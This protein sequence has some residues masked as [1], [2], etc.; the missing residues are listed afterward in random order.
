MEH[1]NPSPKIIA[2]L[3]YLTILG[4]IASLIFNNNHPSSLAKFHIR[5]ALG[6]HL[7]FVAAGLVISVPIVGWIT[8]GLAWLFAFVLWL[9][10]VLDA[11]AESEDKTVPILGDQFQEWFKTL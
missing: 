1:T 4:W 7:I 11:I 3:A 6:I 2:L 9:I 8:G 10:G 5:Q